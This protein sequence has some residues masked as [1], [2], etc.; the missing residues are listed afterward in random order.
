VSGVAISRASRTMSVRMCDATRQ[1][2][3]RRERVDDE[4]HIRHPGPGRDVGQIRHPQLR[5]GRS[6]VK[7]RF[8]RS[9]ARTASGSCDRGE[10]LPA[11][12]A[13]PLDSHGP[14][15][16][17]DLITADVVAGTRAASTACAPRRPCGSRP[18]A[19]SGSASSAASRAP[20]PTARTAALGGV[21]GARGDLQ[22]P[23]DRLDSELV[24][25]L[26][27]EPDDHFCGRSSSAA[28]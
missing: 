18:T 14:H 3:I 22:H 24:T 27:D 10:H 21:V 11:P 12:T 25:M 8:T 6:A 20:V 9:G 23:A 17:G 28:K 15:Q 4:T 2:T 19:P 16:P 5:S 1:P 7:F 26:V 13:D